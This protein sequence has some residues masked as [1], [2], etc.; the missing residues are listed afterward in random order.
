MNQLSF[1]YSI[2][3]LSPVQQFPHII[4]S[5]IL[6]IRTSLRGESIFRVSSPTSWKIRAYDTV[7]FS[8]CSRHQNLCS[9]IDLRLL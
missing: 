8:F 1:F 3:P 4:P 2:T 5:F 7:A 6:Q 9:I